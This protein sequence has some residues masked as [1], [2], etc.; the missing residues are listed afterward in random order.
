MLVTLLGI[1]MLAKLA[2]DAKALPPMLVTGMLRPPIFIVSG[3]VTAPPEPVYPVM[4]IAPLLVVKVNWARTAAGSAKS[5]RSGS[6]TLKRVFIAH[7]IF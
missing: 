6:R 7:S 4:V 2:Q 5:N 1:L 3:R